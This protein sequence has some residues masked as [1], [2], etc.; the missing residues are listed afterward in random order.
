VDG[1]AG[2]AGAV[3]AGVGGGEQALYLAEL[4]VGVLQLSGAAGENVEA[5]VV[6]YCHLVGE[7]AEV[8]GEGGDALRELEA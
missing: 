2:A 5:V 6:A 1:A 3:H 8:P 7:A 4:G